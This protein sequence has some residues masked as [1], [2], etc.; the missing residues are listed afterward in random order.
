MCKNFSKV[1]SELVQHGSGKLV[2]IS[3][4]EGEDSITTLVRATGMEIQVAFTEGAVMKDLKALSG[5]QKSIVALAFILS[6]QQMDPAPFYLFDEVDAALDVE[7]RYLY[8]LN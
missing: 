5:G 1:F 8:L 4:T 6:I 7:H 2:L 3:D